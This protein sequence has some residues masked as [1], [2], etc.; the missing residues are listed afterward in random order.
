MNASTLLRDHVGDSS[1]RSLLRRIV[2]RRVPREEVEDIVQAVVCEAL[3]A[4]RIPS[5][6]DELSPWLVGIARHKVADHFRGHRDESLCDE[7]HITPSPP[8]EARD[9]LRRVLA[10]AEVNACVRQ[11]MNLALREADGESYADLARSEAA[12]EAALRQ[13]VSRFRRAMASRWLGAAGLVFLLAMTPMLPRLPE[14]ETIGPDLDGATLAAVDVCQGAWTV[15][16]W[17]GAEPLVIGS[18]V[19]VGRGH[20]HLSALSGSVA[21]AI[22]SVKPLGDGTEEWTLSSGAAGKIVTIVKRTGARATLT[23]TG[24]RFAGVAT[25]ERD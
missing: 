12:S 2:A 25:L 5:S 14:Y 13:R 19:N 16:S 7:A 21:F 24:G 1:V 23:L 9:L 17:T 20:V 22:A 6:K 10:D 4:K 8:L 18:R 3:A 11:A 15:T